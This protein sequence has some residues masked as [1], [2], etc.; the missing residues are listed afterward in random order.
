MAFPFLTI[1]MIFIIFLFFRFSTLRK[2]QD[3]KINNFWD[4][5]YDAEHT[6]ARDISNLPY[7]KV[8]LSNFPL[9]KWDDDEIRMIEDSIRSLSEK[10]IL[11]LTGKTNTELK[12]EYGTA[13]LNVMSEIGENFNDLAVLLT[14]YGKALMQKGDFES[15]AN[16][17]EYGASIKS[18][19][20]S[21]YMLLGDCYI[22]LHQER[23]LN[24]IKEQVQSMHLLLEHKII[25]YLD[26]LVPNT[27]DFE[28]SHEP[29]D[30]EES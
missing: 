20:S 29:I 23:K 7:I 9:D 26:S 2:K 24:T 28:M 6:P 30:S 27:E 3:E 19:V 16:V 13:N 10:R 1:F 25:S 15:A 18:D 14:D 4:H 8:P 12:L 11:N 17:F 22:A 21:N 5:E